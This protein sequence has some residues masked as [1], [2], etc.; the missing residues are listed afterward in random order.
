MDASVCGR[1]GAATA[2][3]ADAAAD[4]RTQRPQRGDWHS[5][6]PGLDAAAG[7]PRQGTAGCAV[8]AV[9]FVARMEYVSWCGFLVRSCRSASCCALA[10][11]RF[12]SC[13]PVV[14]L[15]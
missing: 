10:P 13:Y 7:P 3:A 2:R 4:A 9:E 12:V 14:P 15:I 1:L 11:R 6:A 8:A 5:A